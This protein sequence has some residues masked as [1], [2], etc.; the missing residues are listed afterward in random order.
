MIWYPTG[1]RM[2]A[3]KK[4]RGVNNITWK[5]KSLTIS[6]S[7]LGLN[8]IL[9]LRS[10]AF[11]TFISPRFTS[12]ASSKQS[13]A[14]ELQGVKDVV[15]KEW[16]MSWQS[17]TG[18]VWSVLL[19]SSYDGTIHTQHPLEIFARCLFCAWPSPGPIAHASRQQPISQAWASAVGAGRSSSSSWG[20]YV[21]YILPL[22]GATRYFD[23]FTDIS[24]IF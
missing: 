2:M 17:R 21:Q 13:A 20:A 18:N 4:S 12:P 10:H 1:P 22:G 19:S 14:K 9:L 3:C 16:R 8:L 7:Q 5:C 15:C 11:T 24:N 23:I 6:K